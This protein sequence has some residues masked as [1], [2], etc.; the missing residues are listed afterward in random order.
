[1]FRFTTAL[2]SAGDVITDFSSLDDTMELSHLIFGAVT[3]TNDHL[4]D[5]DFYIGSSAHD[6]TD[7]II[8]NAGTGALSYDSDGDGGLAAVQFALLSPNLSLTSGDFRIV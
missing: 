3:A 6:S 2:M 4:T 8:Y 7:R 5:D 1:M